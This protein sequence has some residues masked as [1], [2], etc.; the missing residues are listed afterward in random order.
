MNPVIGIS[1][2]IEPAEGFFFGFGMTSMVNV[3]AM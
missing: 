3:C 1:K 2:P